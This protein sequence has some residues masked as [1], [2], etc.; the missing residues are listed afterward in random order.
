LMFQAE[1]PGSMSCGFAGHNAVGM[2]LGYVQLLV[3][4]NNTGDQAAW[5]LAGA[6]GIEVV[7]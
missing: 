1:L 6:T 5:V 4:T 3:D 2:P 7:I